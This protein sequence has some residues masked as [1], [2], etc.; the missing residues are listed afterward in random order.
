MLVVLRQN[1]IQRGEKLLE[2]MQ[3][4]FE[5]PGTSKKVKSAMKKKNVSFSID[6]DD[7]D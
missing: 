6:K 4:E 7:I 2:E 3:R 5:T 1:G